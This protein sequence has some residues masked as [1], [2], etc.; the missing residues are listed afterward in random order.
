MA[1]FDRVLGDKPNLALSV[2]RV[3]MHNTAE[4]LLKTTEGARKP[5]CAPTCS[6]GGAVHQRGSFGATT[7]YDYGLMEDARNGGSLHTIWQWIHHQKTLNDGTPV[8]KALFRRHDG[9]WD[10]WE[11]TASA[12]AA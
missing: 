4:Q 2:T 9:D 11:S 5:E 1:V 8:T 3:R 7:A 12:T 10:G 6:R